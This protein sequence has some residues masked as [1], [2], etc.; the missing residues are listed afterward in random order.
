MTGS[1]DEPANQFAR[2]S[3]GR[4]CQ[5]WQSGPGLIRSA[6]CAEAGLKYGARGYRVTPAETGGSSA[7]RAWLAGFDRNRSKRSASLPRAGRAEKGPPETA[8]VR[9]NR[10]ATLHGVTLKALSPSCCVG[11]GRREI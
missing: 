10:G 2:A 1:C 11:V 6:L 4:P 9:V 8:L 7:W 5:W 3:F